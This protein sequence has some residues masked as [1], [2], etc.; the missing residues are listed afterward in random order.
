MKKRKGEKR[1][2]DARQQATSSRRFAIWAE[3]VEEGREKRGV[4]KSVV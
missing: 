4:M 2:I 1:C 3:Q